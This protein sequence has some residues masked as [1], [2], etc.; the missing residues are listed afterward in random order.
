M[1]QRS[2]TRRV[3]SGDQDGFPSI[4][5][6]FVRRVTPEPSAFITYSS[7][8][9][10]SRSDTKAIRDPSGDQTGERSADPA[11]WSVMRVR[12]EPSARTRKMRK[13]PDLLTLAANVS[14]VPVGD[15][16]GV[17]PRRPWSTSGAG[18]RSRPP[19]HHQ[20]E[21][22]GRES[23]EERDPAAV[24]R[25]R[26]L[27]VDGTEAVGEVGEVQARG[28]DREQVRSPARS[29]WNAM[30][31]FPEPQMPGCARAGPGARAGDSAAAR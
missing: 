22:A 1:Q 20:I 5:A 30:S 16:A 10:P 17:P 8:N 27:H 13:G 4:C 21:P 19:H 2:N 26:R 25:P 14:R 29:E 12:P 7:G 28:I 23:V 24:R 11:A 31:P 18:G 6:L 3:P 9:P 15:H